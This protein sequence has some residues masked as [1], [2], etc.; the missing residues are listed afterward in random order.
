MFLVA[1]VCVYVITVSVSK[2]ARKVGL[3][4]CFFFM[5]KLYGGVE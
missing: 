4:F 1:I 2:M 3:F 5:I